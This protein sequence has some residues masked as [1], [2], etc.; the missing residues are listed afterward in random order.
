MVGDKA[1]GSIPLSSKTGPPCAMT[2]SFME[3][4]LSLSFQ[5]KLWDKSTKEECGDLVERE[6]YRDLI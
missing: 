2:M 6:A 3:Q 1:W 4:C 5:D